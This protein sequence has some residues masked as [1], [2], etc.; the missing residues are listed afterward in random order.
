VNVEAESFGRWLDGSAEDVGYE[1]ELV[2]A[3]QQA[4]CECL[5][6]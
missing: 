6:H 5:S 3:E 4:A 2:H 1:A